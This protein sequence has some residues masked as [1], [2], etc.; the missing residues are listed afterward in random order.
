ML[1]IYLGAHMKNLLV[2]S[3][4]LAV[5]SAT[6]NAYQ[7]QAQCQFNQFQGQCSVLNYTNMVLHCSLQAQGQTYSGFYAYGYENVVLYPGQYAYVYVGAN[8]G[9]MDPLVFVSGFANCQGGF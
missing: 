6:A 5:F 4:L 9:Y 2:V 3:S 7:L 8:N 1:T